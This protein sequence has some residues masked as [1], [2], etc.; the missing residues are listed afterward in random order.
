MMSNDATIV[1]ESEKGGI[2][3]ALLSVRQLWKLLTH[4]WMDAVGG[5]F[6]SVKIDRAKRLRSDLIE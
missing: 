3:A 6:D 4:A 5:A 2:A 1:A